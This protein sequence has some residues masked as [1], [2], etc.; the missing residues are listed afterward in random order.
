MHRIFGKTILKKKSQCNVN[1]YFILLSLIILV[2]HLWL[3]SLLHLLISCY[4]RGNKSMVEC[5]LTQCHAD[6]NCTNENGSTPLSRTQDTQII[7]LLLQHGAVAANLYKYSNLLPDG[8][9]REAAQSTISLFMVGD[10]GAGKSTLTKALSVEKKGIKGWV[11]K[12]FK[13]SD[14]K[15]KTA[16]IECH[17]IHSSRIGHFTIY[18][19]AGH[20]EFHNSHDTVIRSSIS[21][22]S[23]GMFLFVIDLTPSLDD[24]RRTV[25]YW[26][27][28]IQNQVCIE[29]SSAVVSKPY[30][31]A[32]GSHADSVKSE[33]ELKEKQ[34]I[35]QSFCKETENIN[36]VDYVTV[37]CR[38]SESESL[39]QLRAH[40][41]QTHDTLQET[42]PVVTFRDHCFHVYLVSECANQ[43]GMQLSSLMKAIESSPFTSKDLLPQTLQALHEACNNINKRGVMLYIQTQSIESSWIIIDKDMLLR[44]INGSLFAPNDFTEHK[45]LT[46]TGVVPFSKIASVFKELDTQLII[47]FSIH[48]EFCREMT[49]EDGLK[50]VTQTH[51]K[52]KEEH[53]FLFPALT[54]LIPPPDLWQPNPNINYSEYSSCWILQ[55]HE[56]HHYF[57]SR[58]REVLLLRLA[59][60]NALPV[61]D[62]VDHQNPALKQRCTIWRRGIKW[63]TLSSIDALVEMTDERV[64][65]LL[66]CK[67]GKELK[68]VKL[69]TQVMLE[70]Q[71]VKKEFCNNVVTVE[72]FVPNPHYPVNLE[73]SVSLQEIAYSISCHEDSVLLSVDTPLDITQLVFFEPYMF[74]NPQCL[75]DLFCKDLVSCYVSPQFI[76]CISSNIS[77]VD[78]FCTLLNVSLHKVA[79][80]SSS[81]DYDKSVRMFLEWQTQSDGTYQCLR[82]YMDKYSIF[83][84][85]N[86]LVSYLNYGV[87]FCLCT[88][89]NTLCSE[90]KESDCLLFIVFSLSTGDS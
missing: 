65:V 67:K 69:R 84:G 87:V 39:T 80:D 23:S 71:S 18:D 2:L 36:F 35:V 86:I 8:S 56:H 62:E 68:L 58:F 78:D 76:E 46:H 83:S 85:R 72:K 13:V 19:L 37:D 59:F 27:S 61:S 54:S 28:F 5:L 52:Y 82:Q 45:A 22:P 79:V 44:E 25:S 17:T 16:G 90:S 14:V 20:R 66:R 24:L 81:S 6:P 4:R 29:P 63:T 53:H 34:S 75:V 30:L 47:D 11:A 89:K 33:S 48:M 74:C 55:C 43:P 42:I 31:L 49:V 73:L 70:I 77:C 64:L 41:L 12:R 50:L 51:P 40:M 57:T 88:I 3:D 9:P 1:H 7:R 32:V 26:L 21:G 10:K 38:Y 15:E 60:K